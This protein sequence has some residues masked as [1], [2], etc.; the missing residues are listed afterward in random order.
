MRARR[1]AR[2]CAPGIRHARRP[3]RRGRPHRRP[4]DLRRAREGGRAHRR[5]GD[6]AAGRAPV[7]R[8]AATGDL[9]RGPV[10]RGLR[11]R[12]VERA[13]A[14]RGRGRPRLPRHVAA[15][16]AARRRARG[17]R[18]GR[19]AGAHAGLRPLREHAAA[20]SAVRARGAARLPRSARCLGAPRPRPPP[21]RA[22]LAAAAAFLAVALPWHLW[23]LWRWDG[24]FVLVYLGDATEKLGGHPPAR[25]YVRAAAKTMLPWLP[26]AGLGAWRVRRGRGDA[27]RLLVVWTLVGYGFLLTAAKHSPRFLML[28]L[29]AL[30][31]WTALGLAPWLPPLRRLAGG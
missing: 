8:Q 30:A 27:L 15:R 22:L 2:S 11:H 17:A 28:L 1:G 6:V 13:T 24:A 25:V 3:S 10:V 5:L 16:R 18:R 7:L 23:A 9:A 29:P 12:D 14:R 4:G 26:V 19:G 21:L 20:R 31:L